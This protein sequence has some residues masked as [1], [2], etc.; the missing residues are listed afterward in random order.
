[1]LIRAIRGKNKTPF[2][3]MKLPFLPLILLT[4]TLILLTS[5]H[6]RP[7][8]IFIVT[9][10]QGYGDM[11][12]HGN[13]WLNTPNLDR[14]HDE[15]ISLDD[16]HV[17]PY[18]TPTR[19]ALLSGRYSTRVGTWSVTEGRQ[20]LEKDETTM[21]EIFNAS[22][23][24]TGMFGKWHLGDAFPY[25][26]RFRGFDDV[27]CHKAG[28]VNEIGNPVGNDYFDDT[29]FRNGKAEKFDGYCTDIF[30]RETRRFI[31]E[32]VDEKSKQ[33]FF[34]YLP[35]NAMHGPFTVADRF[36]DPFRK[37]G[38]PES[39]SLF[40]GMIQ[41]FDE[42]LGN[43]LGSLKQ[44]GIDED[45]LVVFMGDN[46]TAA[47]S[48]GKLDSGGFNAAMKG[49]KGNVYE[50]GHRV[51]CFARWPQSLKAGGSIDNL[52]MHTDWLPTLTELCDLKAPKSLNWDGRSIASLLEGK[53][54]N[55]K[56]R[57]IFVS[58]QAGQLSL[59]KPG[60]NNEEKYPHFAVLSEK[61]RYVDGELY[62]INTDPSQKTNVAKQ[63][64]EVTRSLYAEYKQWFEDVTEEGGAYNRF[65][66]G[67]REENPT[68]FTTRDWHPTD[69]GVIWKMELVEDDSLFVNG[70]WAVDVQ[71][72]GS[73]EIRIARFP[74]DAESPAKAN[75]ARIQISNIN[76]K[77]KLDP[78][79]I[80]ATFKVDLKKGHAKLQT[81]LRD[82]ENGKERG[83]YHIKV[84]R[85]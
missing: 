47:G 80:S 62:D 34:V 26:P 73:Y 11:S 5:L 4:S 30:F 51:A 56:E 23:Y 28:G 2:Q 69:G 79:A 75:Q 44:W 14:L 43:L 53:T 41:N 13:P 33:P 24:R 67:A 82:A 45:T 29:Y 84:T 71:R 1:V 15:G 60:G 57:S 39:R 77:V 50:G 38:V 7:N 46:G 32:G 76:Q 68:R 74:E 31:K 8:V 3:F 22:G 65:I 83:A 52:T 58:K 37:Q 81:W 16:Y 55:W 35:L 42:N 21:A 72:S 63:H 12:C 19:A 66:L 59:W 70:F 78:D 6:A 20:L 25:A 64:P 18:C 61:W 49:K 27:V 48:D 36:S 17:D 54:K 40:Y 85:L 10:D 9:D